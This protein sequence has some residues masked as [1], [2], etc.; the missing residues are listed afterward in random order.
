MFGSPRNR[1]RGALPMDAAGELA[2]GF[3]VELGR[4]ADDHGVCV[5][6]EP[7]PASLGCDFIHCVADAKALVDQVQSPGLGLHLDA[8]SMHS[9]REDAHRLISESIAQVRHF[10]ISEVGYGAFG[11]TDVDHQRFALALRSANYQNVAS[12]EMIGDP[13]GGNRT[14]VLASV[15][16]AREIYL[17]H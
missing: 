14:S 8:S 17:G 10:H 3:F 11:S 16:N 15:A 7:L 2:V 9:N 13:N 6:I 5:C 4:I 12:I 1:I